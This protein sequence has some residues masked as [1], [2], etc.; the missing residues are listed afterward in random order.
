MLTGDSITRQPGNAGHSGSGSASIFP[1]PA[2]RTVS[3]T[4]SLSL[5]AVASTWAEISNLPTAPVNPD[6]SGMGR[7]RIST[8][9]G[10]LARFSI[11]TPLDVMAVICMTAGLMSLAPATM[12]NSTVRTSSTR[13][14]AGPYRI[15]VL[16]LY[17]LLAVPETDEVR[18]GVA[19]YAQEGQVGVL[20]LV[21]PEAVGDLLAQVGPFVVHRRPGRTA[22]RRVAD[23]AWTAWNSHRHHRP[24]SQWTDHG[25]E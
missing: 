21:D 5:P 22:P 10:G 20:L 6:G 9:T 16:V 11:M 24:R 15:L 13:V 3:R 7:G 12:A 4:G 18:G 14:P 17:V 19:A 1:S 2:I 23:W 8:A 25:Q